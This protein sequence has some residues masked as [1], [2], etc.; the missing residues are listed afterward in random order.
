MRNDESVNKRNDQQLQEKDREIKRIKKEYNGCR[1]KYKRA[2]ERVYV[3]QRDNQLLKKQLLK[4]DQAS[5]A[6]LN[7]IGLD[8]NKMI[9]EAHDETMAARDALLL[10]HC[11]SC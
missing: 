9:T 7:A 4:Q 1:T 2:I 10:Q 11:V 3:V 6:L 5:N 8:A